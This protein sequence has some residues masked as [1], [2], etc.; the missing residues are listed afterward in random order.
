MSTDRAH[1][2][3]DWLG[4]C[5]ETP[6][7][8]EVAKAELSQVTAGLWRSGQSRGQVGEETVATLLASVLPR[9][10]GAS[11]ASPRHVLVPGVMPGVVRRQ[12]LSSRPW[13]LPPHPLAARGETGQCLAGCVWL[14]PDI[15]ALKE[16]LLLAD[17]VAAASP[18]PQGHSSAPCAGAVLCPAPL[19]SEPCPPVP[20]LCSWLSSS[21]QGPMMAQGR[22]GV[23]PRPWRSH[24]CRDRTQ[25]CSTPGL[26]GPHSCGFAPEFWANAYPNHEATTRALWDCQRPGAHTG[27]LALLNTSSRSTARP[28]HP[29]QGR[30]RPV[31]PGRT[32]PVG[33]CECMP[34]LLLSCDWNSGPW[35]CGLT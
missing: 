2:G 14:F 9:P 19:A 31:R 22:L 10:R 28:L 12:G 34:V 23:R 32:H 7:V 29:L 35:L 11:A 20:G 26:P 8:T 30:T 33:S 27:H 24:C 1:G 16:A 21:P 5:W 3:Q 6:G 25:V 18:E 4:P 17:S 15:L 13:H